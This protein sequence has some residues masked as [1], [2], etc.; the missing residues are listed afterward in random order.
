MYN[1]QNLKNEFNG[2]I[3]FKRRIEREI[4]DLG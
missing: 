2:K 3:F 1:F 4:R